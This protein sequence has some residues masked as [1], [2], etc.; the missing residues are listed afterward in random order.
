M[1]SYEYLKLDL[2]THNKNTTDT[3]LLTAAG[4]HGWELIQITSNNIAYMI[5]EIEDEISQP[6]RGAAP[7]GE[8]IAAPHSIREVLEPANIKGKSN[9]VLVRE[10]RILLAMAAGMTSG[11]V[12]WEQLKEYEPTLPQARVFQTLTALLSMGVIHRP[13]R[14]VYTGS[15]I[16]GEYLQKLRNY[17]AERGLSLDKPTPIL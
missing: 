15:D 14:G 9:E 2:N 6:A 8:P 1:A 5:R 11:T 10:I 12:I 16:T 17:A 7:E 13:D 3:D 4:A